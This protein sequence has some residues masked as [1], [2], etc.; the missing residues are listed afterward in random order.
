MNYIKPDS[1]A[2]VLPSEIEDIISK[3]PKGKAGGHNG[4]QYEHLIHTKQVISPVVANIF[5]WMLRTG[6]VPDNLKAVTN[7]VTPLTIIVQ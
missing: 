6:H 7:A 1:R 4:L 5:T 3:C 2:C